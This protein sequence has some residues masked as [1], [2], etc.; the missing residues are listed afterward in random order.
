MEWVPRVRAV[1]EKV[2][3]P[4]LFRVP[5]PSRVVPSEKLTVPDTTPVVA[6]V[7][8]GEGEGGPTGGGGA[9]G[10]M[11][12]GGGPGGVASGPRW[13]GGVGGSA[14]V[15]GRCAPASCGQ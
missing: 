6:G 11:G 15:S 13:V 1:V 3:T 4:L 12:G 8:G 2:V 5:V 14:G 10:G 9:G 7:G